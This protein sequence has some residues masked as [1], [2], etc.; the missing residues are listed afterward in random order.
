MKICNHEQLQ[1]HRANV[2]LQ[3]GLAKAVLD[4]LEHD[5]MEALHAM[6]FEPIGFNPLN[7]NPLN[8]MEQLTQTFHNLVSFTA[9]SNLLENFPES[10]GLRLAPQFAPG[11]DITSIEPGVVAAEVF[12]AVTPGNND[13]LRNDARNVCRAHADHRF[14]FFY[15]PN[16]DPALLENVRHEFPNVQIQPLT[17]LEIL[18]AG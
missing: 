6:R 5:P 16:E 3:A 14:V 15:S 2:I 13:K 10:G 8:L 11:L 4:N 12:A 7:G 18:G 17:W 9:A 1:E